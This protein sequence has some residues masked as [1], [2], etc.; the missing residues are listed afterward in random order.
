MTTVLHLP[1]FGESGD[2]ELGSE[3]WSA[4]IAQLFLEPA[5]LQAAI[6]TL[7]ARLRDALPLVPPTDGPG[8]TQN[9]QHDQFFR[10]VRAAPAAHARLVSVLEGTAALVKLLGSGEHV[11]IAE[12]IFDGLR[13]AAAQ[14]TGRALAG[15]AALGSF[16]APTEPLSPM[17]LWVLCHHV[18]LVLIHATVTAHARC[19]D[20]SRRGAIPEAVASS[21]PTC[22]PSSPPARRCDSRGSSAVRTMRRSGRR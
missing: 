18:F 2:S 1:W 5:R 16:S 12:P 4:E 6:P 20:A 10:V 17:D 14:A 13:L 19:I 3:P 22:A 7:L 11:G 15:T 9:R 8:S 21:T